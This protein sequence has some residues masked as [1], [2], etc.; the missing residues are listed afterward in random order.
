[1]KYKYKAYIH[2]EWVTIEQ[3]E[4]DGNIQSKLRL[5]Q[6]RRVLEGP[7]E[8]NQLFDPD[9]A[10][11]ERILDQRGGVSTCSKNKHNPEMPVE[12]LV[13]WCLLPYSR[14][15]W[16]GIDYWANTAKDKL[17]EFTRN[18]QLPLILK[19]LVSLN[20]SEPHVEE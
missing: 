15:T 8:E 6:A 16:E 9:Y 7:T 20:H 2:C 13:K 10:V 18:T 11:I 12:Y 19:T 5:F 14:C 1:M 3:L 4:R 17:D